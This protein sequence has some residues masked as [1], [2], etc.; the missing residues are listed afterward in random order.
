MQHFWFLS[1]ARSIFP[2]HQNVNSKGRCDLK[3]YSSTLTMNTDL[4]RKQGIL[5][6]EAILSGTQKINKLGGIT[7]EVKGVQG[8]ETK[9]SLFTRRSQ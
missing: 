2:S 8:P 1:F 7:R 9:V 5:T 3:C 6:G 4:V